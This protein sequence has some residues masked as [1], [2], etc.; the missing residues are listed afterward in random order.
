MQT[1]GVILTIIVTKNKFFQIEVIFFYNK[2]EVIKREMLF[3]QGR[4]IICRDQNDI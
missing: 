2:I 1:F 4:N 3:T